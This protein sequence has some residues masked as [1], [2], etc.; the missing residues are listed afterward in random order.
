MRVG[1][2]VLAEQVLSIIV[3]VWSSDHAV[4]VLA[5]RHG[6]VLGES[7]KVSRA[8]MIEFDHDHWAVNAIV[9]D[10]R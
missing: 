9:I 8:L 1:L 4:N 2:V 10:A 3:A 7:R 6:G 5:R